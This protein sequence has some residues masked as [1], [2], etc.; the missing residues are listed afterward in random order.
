MLTFAESDKPRQEW[1]TIPDS[2]KPQEYIFIVDLDGHFLYAS[3]YP[4][5]V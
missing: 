2:E 3:Q 5:I 4:E 1:S